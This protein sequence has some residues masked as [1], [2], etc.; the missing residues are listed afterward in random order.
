MSKLNR[1]QVEN[2]IASYRNHGYK[3]YE[4][5]DILS[6]STSPVG[7][8]YQQVAQAGFADDFVKDYGLNPKV[9]LADKA[10]SMAESAFVGGAKAWAGAVE[11]G[12]KAD[13]TKNALINKGASAVMG[14]DVKPLNTNKAENYRKEVDDVIRHKDDSRKAVGRDGIDW[15]DASFNMVSSAPKYVLGGGAGAGAKLSTR[16][17]EQAIRGGLDG[18]TQHASNNKEMGVNTAWGAVGGV[19][20]ELIGTGIRK[21]VTKAYNAVKGN[22]TPHAKEMQRLAQ[23]HGISMTAGDTSKNAVMRNAEIQ[24]ERVP[25]V[26]MSGGR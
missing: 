25:L 13:D 24:M 16:L 6:K 22:T 18:L 4:I 14:R 3:D 7:K 19:G 15:V 5:V 17:G 10:K 21:G 11:L 12:L 23:Q 8:Y 20:G 9:G 1:K 26:G 2:V